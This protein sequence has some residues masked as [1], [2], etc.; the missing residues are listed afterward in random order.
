MQ[1]LG[2]HLLFSLSQDLQSG[3]ASPNSLFLNFLTPPWNACLCS[4]PWSTQTD[5]VA[6]LTKVFLMTMPS[7]YWTCLTNILCVSWI[8]S[9]ANLNRGAEMSSSK[10][11]LS[12]LHLRKKRYV[13]PLLASPHRA[14]FLALLK[15]DIQILPLCIFPTNYPISLRESNCYFLCFLVHA[16]KQL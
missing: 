5:I 11:Q 9:P 16:T 2:L 13:L 3:H 1:I 7:P 12:W 15:L 14:W 10:M 6:L 4:D 8:F